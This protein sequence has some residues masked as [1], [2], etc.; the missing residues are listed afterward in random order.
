MKKLIA[1]SLMI[2]IVSAGCKKDKGDPPVLPP[3]ESMI[4]DFSMFVSDKKS[5]EI[6][7]IKGT[8]N[9]SWEFSA[10]A[11]GYWKLITTGSLIIPTTLF[12]MVV[13]Q[14]PEYVSD[15]TWQWIYSTK[16]GDNNYK[17][18]LT[19]QIG[20]NE[21]IWKMYITKDGAAGFTDFLWFEGT[22]AFD[23]KSGTWTLFESNANPVSLISVAWEKPAVNQGK[24]KYTYEKNTELKGS[25]IEYGLTSSALNAYFIIH[26]WNG[27]KFIDVNIEWSTTV[28]NG[29]VKSSYLGDENWHCWD[30]N[31]IN[32]TCP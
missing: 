2:I 20:S 26:Y 9:N 23:G 19:G 14:N 30:G 22:S 31:M 5:A 32:V 4:I 29:R 10:I 24:I 16:I 13:D 15:K 27:A 11:V 6:N 28:H 17:A 25:Y 21:V 12:Q 1:L 7:E 3:K 8:D 18:K